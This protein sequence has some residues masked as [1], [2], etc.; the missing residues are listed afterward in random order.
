MPRNEPGRPDL[1]DAAVNDH[2]RFSDFLLHC[3]IDDDNRYPIQF[4]GQAALTVQTM[5]GANWLDSDLSLD[6]ASERAMEASCG[7]YRRTYETG[8]PQ[9]DEVAA[10]IRQDGQEPYWLRWYRSLWPVRSESG[11][12]AIA[13]FCIK[14]PSVQSPM[15][16]QFP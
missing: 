15:S 2:E 6:V 16:R 9:F 8:E 11:A 14:V 1:F 12:F 5:G 3:K 4:S 10:I 13:C 7:L